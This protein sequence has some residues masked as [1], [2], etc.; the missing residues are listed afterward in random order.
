MDSGCVLL[1]I[2]CVWFNPTQY[3]SYIFDKALKKLI[4]TKQDKTGVIN[5]P[6]DQ[7]VHSLTGREDMV[8][9]ARF[10]KVRTDGH[11]WM[12]LLVGLVDQN[13][14]DPLCLPLV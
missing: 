5:D 8:C 1:I 4:E 14:N 13:I 9:F 10:W 6:L 11:V 7:S 12:W 3:L 2:S